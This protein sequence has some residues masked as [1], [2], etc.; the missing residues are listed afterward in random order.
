[1]LSFI[2]QLS[3]LTYLVGL[4]YKCRPPPSTLLLLEN[5]DVEHEVKKAGGWHDLEN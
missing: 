1:M 4:F 2:G 3:M 5:A